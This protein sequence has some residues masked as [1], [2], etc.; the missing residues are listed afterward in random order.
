MRGRGEE[1]IITESQNGI[2]PEGSQSLNLLDRGKATNLQKMMVGGRGRRKM[3][4]RGEDDGCKKA[5]DRVKDNLPPH[6]T[7][8]VSHPHHHARVIIQT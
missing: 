2:G 7:Q 4:A 6:D 5:R 3:V 1:G 8:M